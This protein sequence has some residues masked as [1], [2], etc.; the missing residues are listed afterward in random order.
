MIRVVVVDDHELSREGLAAILAG[1]PEIEVVGTLPD[2]APA[3][4]FVAENAIDV[5]LMDVAMPVVDGITA[6]AQVLERTPQAAVIMLTTLP[7]DEH[8]RDALRAGA[9]GY[10]LKT[11]SAEE[12]RFA[13]RA[14]KDGR[15]WFDPLVLERLAAGF[16]GLD[17]ASTGG[18][19]EPGE[20][21]EVLMALTERELEV[22][23]EI[24]RGHSN[25]EIGETL[26]LSEKTVK[27]Y[28][29]RI[30]GKLGLSSRVQAVVL[31]FESGF[32]TRASA[33]PD[34]ES[35][36]VNERR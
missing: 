27:T 34:A 23:R 10:L 21:P 5:V 26:F 12:L 15:R 13:V 16:A 14:A 11:C 6:T 35:P 22:F 8:V 32:I 24:G 7:D 36:N 28:V 9:R 18:V 29:N 20:V 4:A 1:E 3:A 31:A 17:P 25:A 33:T 30:L 2:G 19:D